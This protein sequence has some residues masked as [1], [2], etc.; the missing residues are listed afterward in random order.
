MHP[1]PSKPPLLLLVEDEAPMRKFLRTY[2]QGAGYEVEEAA[3]GQDALHLAAQR[4]PNLVV[5]DL[6]LPD[7]DGQEVLR[8]L[9]EWLKA[10]I[11]ILS[12]RDQDAQKVAA[13]DNGADDYLTNLHFAG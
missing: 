5:L 4:V 9:R 12:V 13:L 6:G 7:L 10:P 2:L 3:N 8:Q 1:D 11:I